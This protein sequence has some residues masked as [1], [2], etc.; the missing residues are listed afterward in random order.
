MNAR[1]KGLVAVHK[2]KK[3]LQAR[4]ETVEGPGY[5]PLFF[6]G[7]MIAVHSDY[8]GAFDLMAFSE[9]KCLYGLQVCDIK[10]KLRN[11]KK[12]YDIA[13]CGDLWC[14]MGVRKGFNKYLVIEVD[15]KMHIELVEENVK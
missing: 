3:V 6:K 15:G 10:N 8:F 9:I 13:G 11:A 2:V 12:I 14:H 4:G 1:Q 5:K 7:K